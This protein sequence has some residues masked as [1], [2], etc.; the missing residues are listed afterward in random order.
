MCLKSWILCIKY[1]TIEQARRTEKKIWEVATNYEILSA[2]IMCRQTK[3]IISIC[4]KRLEKLNI[5]WRQV[6]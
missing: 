1:D 2:T 3:F 4:L 5:C 6:M